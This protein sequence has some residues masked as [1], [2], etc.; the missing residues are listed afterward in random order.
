MSKKSNRPLDAPAE[1]EAAFSVLGYR[2]DEMWVAHCLEMD[3]LGFGESRD[4]A[5]NELSELMEM[6]ISFALQSECL[7]SLY[8]PAPPEY[9]QRF[10]ELNRELLFAVD[11][12]HTAEDYFL[13]QL[14]RPAVGGRKFELTEVING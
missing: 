10:G 6:K 4:E 3:I 2:E 9:W 11:P 7:E 5:L 12:T 8:S 13:S 14:R 1:F